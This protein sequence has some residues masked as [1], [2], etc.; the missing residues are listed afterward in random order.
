MCGLWCKFSLHRDVVHA[1]TDVQHAG[2]GGVDLLEEVVSEPP[3]EVVFVHAPV[4]AA[5][6]EGFRVFVAGRNKTQCVAW[7]QK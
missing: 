4:V 6:E 2:L 3:Q 7:R 5:R 1:S